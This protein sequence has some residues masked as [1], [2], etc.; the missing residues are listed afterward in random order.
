[1]ERWTNELWVGQNLDVLD[2]IASAEI[3]H[4]GGAFP[5]AHGVE[6]V[7]EGVS[8]QLATFPDMQLS[9]DETIADGDL[10]AVRWSGTGTNEG[11]FLPGLAPTG[12]ETAISGI[13]IY[14]V[15]CGQIVES[16]SEINGLAMLRQIQ[17]AAAT[18]VP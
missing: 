3:I 10:V 6:A 2:E 9:I 15:H 16:W 11:E 17:G 8:S 4:H 18:P 12:Q 7:M 13:N 1:M 5:D 14:Q